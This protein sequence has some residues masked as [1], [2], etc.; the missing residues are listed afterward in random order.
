ML[1]NL[2]HVNMQTIIYTQTIEPAFL[3]LMN[4][5]IM[6][7]LINSNKDLQASRPHG[8]KSPIFK[9][10]ICTIICVILDDLCGWR[11]KWD[12]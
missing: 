2:N 4:C 10:M 12:L 11:E 7:V 8:G 9:D 6:H 5:Y 3:G 1:V